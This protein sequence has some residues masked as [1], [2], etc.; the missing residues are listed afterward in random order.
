GIRRE[1]H[2]VDLD[3]ARGCRERMPL[4]VSYLASEGDGVLGRRQP[5]Q[6]TFPERLEVVDRITRE[7]TEPLLF[8][9]VAV[10][11]EAQTRGEIGADVEVVAAFP[12]RLDRLLHEDRVVA[13]ARPRR[14]D[15]V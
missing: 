5:R 10:A 1:R 6:P 4:R 12:D 3:L 11:R 14:V 15:V 7:L 8:A 2:R 9:V 13:G